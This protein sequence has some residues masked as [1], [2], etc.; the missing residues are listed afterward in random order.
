LHAGLQC[1]RPARRRLLAHWRRKR[2]NLVHVVTEGP[3]GWSALGAA[4]ALAVPVTSG[5]HTNF[6]AYTA[7]YGLGL[8]RRL[9]VAGLRCFHNRTLRTLVP[10]DQTRR[11]LAALG[12]Q[13]LFVV[14]RGVDTRLFSPERRR[15]DL[16]LRWGCGPADSVMTVVGRLAPEKNVALAVRAYEE[17]RRLRPRTRLVLVGEGPERRRL[18]QQAGGLVFAGMQRGETLAEHYASAD[19]FLFPSLTETFGNVALEALAS[20]LGV[21]AFDDA[22]PRELIR[23]GD[24][25]LLAGRGDEAAFR[26]HALALASDGELLVRLRRRAALSARRF[27]WESVGREFVSALVG[28]VREAAPEGRTAMP[29]VRDDQVAWSAGA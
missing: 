28:A 12:F 27:G 18:E 5:F 15:H 20:G 29:A 4:R 17:V 11:E 23:S 3:L 16:R 24:N 25:G 7:H 26:A 19:I 8:L 9:L 2:P 10:T 21:V 22:G 13:S 1:G 14:Q 6:H